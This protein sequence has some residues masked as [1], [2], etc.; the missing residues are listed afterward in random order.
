MGF[1]PFACQFYEGSLVNL[2][3]S[4]KDGWDGE[5]S[6]PISPTLLTVAQEILEEIPWPQPDVGAA[7]GGYIDI[8]WGSSL[9]CILR[10]KT[11]IIQ[12]I[13]PDY[14]SSPG[15]EHRFKY[16]SSEHIVA[17]LLEKAKEWSMFTQ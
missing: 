17:Q 11:F 7:D 16:N 12:Y 9:W 1:S 6:L 5:D 10:K 3:A 4:L 8:S 13:P 2:I 14:P 15:K